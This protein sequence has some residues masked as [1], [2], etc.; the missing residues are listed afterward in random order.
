MLIDFKLISLT[1]ISNSR[2]VAHKSWM[3]RCFP[4]QGLQRVFKSLKEEGGK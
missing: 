3:G 1:R 4:R 2:A